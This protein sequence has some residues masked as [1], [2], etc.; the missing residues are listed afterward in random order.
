MEIELTSEKSNRRQAELTFEN[1]KKLALEKQ[2]LEQK[3][4]EVRENFLFL[5]VFWRNYATLYNSFFYRKLQNNVT[6][7]LKKIYY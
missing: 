7:W 5:Q 6:R 4:L 2:I 1:Y 3:K